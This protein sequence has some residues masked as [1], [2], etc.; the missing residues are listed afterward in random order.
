MNE[1][2][3]TLLGFARK[4]GK[5]AVGTS[6]TEYSIVRRKSKLALVAGDISKKSAKEINFLCEKYGTKFAQLN[7]ETYDITKAIGT[8]AGILSIEDEGFASAI[9]EKL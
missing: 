7:I 3:L 9:I 5:L 4:A 6:A 8:R 1:K 2:I